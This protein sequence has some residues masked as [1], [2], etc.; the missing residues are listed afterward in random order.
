M[1]A[2]PDN[3]QNQS[4][5]KMTEDMT[6]TR[7]QNELDEADTIN[8]FA[9]MFRTAAIAILIALAIRTFAFEP[10]SI[11]SGSMLPT[12]QV[13]DYL[14]V[15]KYSYGYSKYSFPGSFVN[16]SGR[17]FYSEPERGDVAVFRKPHGYVDYIK[18]IIGLPGDK[19]AM[20]D[21]ILHINGQPVPRTLDGTYNVDGFAKAFFRYTEIL[22]NGVSHTIIE[23]G[24]SERLDNTPTFVVPA[25][26]FFVMGDNRDGSQDSRVVS[27]VGF[28][29]A[30]NLIGRA[31]VIFFSLGDGAHAWELWK[32]PFAVR[33]S[34]IFQAII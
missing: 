4:R 32:W 9:D 3:K 27:E 15:S 19:V 13:G 26:H 34:R 2:I 10:F 11:P 33:F 29:P 23:K 17:F 16:F 22:P 20:I 31:E 25:G 30:E 7:I 6:G 8:G 28:V 24:D 14:F 21:G 18:R 5:K 1:N 12:L